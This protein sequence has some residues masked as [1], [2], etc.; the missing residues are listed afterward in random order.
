MSAKKHLGFAIAAFGGAAASAA[1]LG[2]MFT[3][4]RGDTREWYGKLEKAPFNPPNAVF[5]PVWTVLYALIATSG[6][7]VWRSEPGKSRTIALRLWAAQMGLNGIWSPL[8]FGAKRPGLALLDQAI[9]L[10]TIVSYIDRTRRFDRPAALM[11]APYAAWVAFATIL[12][13]EIVRR[14]PAP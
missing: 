13:G 3:P 2:S 5:A 8:F 14:N 12:N 10:P 4:A 6:V 7:R 1:L 9:L 11:M